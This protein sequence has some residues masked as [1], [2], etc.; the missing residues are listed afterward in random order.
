MNSKKVENKISKA[1]INNSSKY[2]LTFLIYITNAILTTVIIF[3]YFIFKNNIQTE[4]LEWSTYEAL[5]IFTPLIL[6]LMY[7]YFKIFILNHLRYLITIQFLINIYFIFLL[8]S[9]HLLNQNILLIFTISYILSF[10]SRYIRNNFN[11]S[12]LLSLF[13]ILFIV[14]VLAY[15]SIYNMSYS[16]LSLIV[17]FIVISFIKIIFVV[18]NVWNNCIYC[19]RYYLEFELCAES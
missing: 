7:K 3:I 17:F 1:T 9:S 15:F 8:I 11:I 19:C 16:N 6:L 5:T 13:N 18:A 10:P 2:S 12:L 4:K 14:S